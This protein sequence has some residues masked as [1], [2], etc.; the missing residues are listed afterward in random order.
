MRLLLLCGYFYCMGIS[1]CVGISTVWVFLLCGCFFC[2]GNSSEWV[3]H[4]C[5][6]FLL[7]NIH[8]V[9]QNRIYTPVMAVCMVISLLK[10]PYVHR[11]YV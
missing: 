8:R 4:L 10:K 5:G 9:G 2:V 6:Y 3:F 1:Y 7:Y 11:I